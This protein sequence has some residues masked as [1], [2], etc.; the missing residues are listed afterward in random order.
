MIGVISASWPRCT[1]AVLALALPILTELLGA[2][3]GMASVRIHVTGAMA[4]LVAGA[5]GATIYALG[6]GETST[7]FVL[8]WYSIAMALPVVLG[9]LAAPAVLRW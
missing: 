1:S 5:T 3:R 8:V 7:N 2:L 9:T 6:C 4:G